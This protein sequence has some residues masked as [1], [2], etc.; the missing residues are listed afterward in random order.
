MKV[1]LDNPNQVLKPGVVCEADITN[2]SQKKAVDI[3]SR[4][5]Q[6]SGDGKMFAW[7]VVN[8]NAE[9]SRS[10][11]GEQSYNGVEIL[12]GL[13]VGEKIVID[14]YQKLSEGLKIREP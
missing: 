13:S 14:G 7:K 6:K 11:L 1:E 8:G 3:P 4:C 2:R 10:H 12:T 9:N 5:I